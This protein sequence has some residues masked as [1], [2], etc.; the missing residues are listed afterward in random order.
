MASNTESSSNQ[1]KSGASSS[2]NYYDLLGITPQATEEEIK[3]AYR[4]TA[5]RLR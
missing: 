4:K 1:A 3:R 2:Q 5:L